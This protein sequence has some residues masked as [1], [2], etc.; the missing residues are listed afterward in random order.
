MQ[1]LGESPREVALRG[2][3]EETGIHGVDLSFAAVAEFDLTTPKRREFLAVYR[4]QLQIVPRL[5]VN[6]VRVATIGAGERGY[7]PAGCGDRQA[8]GPVLDRL[9]F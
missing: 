5:T 8:R 9:S 1:E 2:L 4:V 7:E 6:D 3:G